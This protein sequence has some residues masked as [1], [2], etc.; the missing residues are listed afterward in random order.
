MS[1]TAAKSGVR[2]VTTLCIPSSLKFQCYRKLAEK[3]PKS[4][5]INIHL[6][7]GLR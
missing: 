6:P 7:P 2:L 3:W 1:S 5:L 4:D